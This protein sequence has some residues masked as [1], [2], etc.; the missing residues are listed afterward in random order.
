MTSMPEVI[1]SPDA[2]RQFRA[3]RAFERSKL[4]AAIKKFLEESDPTEEGRNRFRLRRP[5]PHAD[6][7]L[8]VGQLRVFYRVVRQRVL[9]VLVGRK[10]GNA[11]LIDDRRFVL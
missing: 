2:V 9:V 8:R 6:Y 5:S 11:L 10:L 4:R 3:L 7:E 1:F